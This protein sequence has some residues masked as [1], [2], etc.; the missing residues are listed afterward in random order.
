MSSFTKSVWRLA[1]KGV[2]A[3]YLGVL[4]VYAVSG[5]AQKIFDAVFQAFLV[6]KYS[7]FISW[8]LLYRP[9]GP[10]P[11]FGGVLLQSWKVLPRFLIWYKQNKK[12][13]MVF[14]YNLKFFSYLLIFIWTTIS[15][16][17]FFEFQNVYLQ[18]LREGGYWDDGDIF[19]HLTTPS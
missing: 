3:L 6:Q 9:V 18:I 11:H 15:N 19:S 12:N 16:I 10:Q 4:K 8:T 13:A 17:S 5:L 14:S 1:Q 7:F 2:C